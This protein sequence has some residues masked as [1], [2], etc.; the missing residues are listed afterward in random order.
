MVPGMNW[1]ERDP[2]RYVEYG[3]SLRAAQ[4]VGIARQLTDTVYNLNQAHLDAK[5]LTLFEELDDA[6]VRTAC[7]TYLVYRG[8]HAHEPRRDGL[9]TRLAAP[10]M[11]HPV[12]G[13]RELFYADIFSS[14]PAP[15]TAALGMPGI[16]DRHSGCVGAYLVE[17][18][19]FDLLLLSLPDNDWY[20][21]KHGPEA[22][23]RSLAQA[24]TQ[25]RRIMD[26]GGGLEAFL[27]DHAVIV[28]GDHSQ[29]PVTRAINLI[30]DLSELGVVGPR[31][32]A[33]AG[34]RLA[35]C[36][37]QRAAMV[38]LLG[39][40]DRD[41]L[42]ALV[43][44]RALRIEGVELAC[45]LE[46]DAHGATV[47][48]V[49][50]RADGEEVHFAPGGDLL[51]SRGASWSLEGA[52]EAFGIDAR[53]GIVESSVYPNGLGRVWAALA[54]A[55]SGEVLL[56]AAPE[57][58]FTDWGGQAHAGGGSHGSLRAEDSLT[59]LILCGTQLPEPQPARW[60]I[61]DVAPMVRRHFGVDD[62]GAPPLAGPAVS[63]A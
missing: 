28:M 43:I 41:R 11:R 31:D 27:A 21:H 36:P 42:R 23:V 33:T 53:G 6:G 60:T 63:S 55:S 56:S 34:E 57:Y 44:S 16:R 32:G 18:D 22:Q 19:L 49:I 13:P 9:L 52:L 8:R 25:L 50:A 39:E 14:S 12:L 48:A 1:Y 15:C 40:E 59:A 30:E 3:S 29:A 26:A 20:S 35:V 2:G 5:V 4:R 45:W 10:L 17:H 46:R 54:C 61:C 51:D 37:S 7:T 62:L 38:Y 47:E 58:E 24:D